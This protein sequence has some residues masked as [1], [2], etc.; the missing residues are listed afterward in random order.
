M[1]NAAL[2]THVDDSLA[3]EQR[4]SIYFASG[5]LA[6]AIA[7]ATAAIAID[8]CN[9]FAY[10]IRSTAYR[11][12]HFA[13]QAT[14]DGASILAIDTDIIQQKPKDAALYVTRGG[15]EDAEKEFEQAIADFNKAIELNP[16]YPDAFEFRGDTYEME[17]RYADQSG[18]KRSTCVE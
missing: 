6:K 3:Y 13:Q 1:S 4:A 2:R 12:M 17:G 14:A 5:D 9:K 11:R 16:K 7:D 10:R 18:R 8:P 15:D